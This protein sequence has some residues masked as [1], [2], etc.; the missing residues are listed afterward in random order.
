MQMATTDQSRWPV[1]IGGLL[2]AIMSLGVVAEE[3]GLRTFV[4]RH[5][6][7][8][9]GADV[10]YTA[11][12]GEFPQRDE[13]GAATAQL[14]ATSYVREDVVDR[15]TRPV[16]FL[17]NG[18]PGA[19]SLW[20]HVGAF[21]PR[22]AELPQDP[23]AEIAPPYRL[24]ANDHTVLDVADLVFVDPIGTGYSRLDDESRLKAI[25]TPQGD[26]KSVADLIRAWVRTN[27]RERSPRWSVM[28]PL[29]SHCLKRS[30]T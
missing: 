9:N 5:Q 12:V 18:G 13:N 17:W 6:G 1:A 7:V 23:D 26:A 28:C 20:L 25:Y 24:V 15:D 3:P 10:R 21:G 11:T 29:C 16:L 30:T 22:R 8:F 27:G 14:F 4:T 19:A 2:L